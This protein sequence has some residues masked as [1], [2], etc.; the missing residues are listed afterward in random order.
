M[1][2]VISWLRSPRF[3]LLILRFDA[4]RIAI[5]LRLHCEMKQMTT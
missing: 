4:N 2:E 5:C 1:C 3:Y